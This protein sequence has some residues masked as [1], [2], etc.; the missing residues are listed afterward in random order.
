MPC[1][2]GHL[3]IGKEALPLPFQ[4]WMVIQGRK[5]GYNY[6]I[7]RSKRGINVLDIPAW[8]SS[9]KVCFGSEED[10]L[11]GSASLNAVS[12]ESSEMEC[13]VQC[14][15]ATMIDAVVDVMVRD[16]IKEEV[17]PRFVGQSFVELICLSDDD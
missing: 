12:Q 11:S 2:I 1:N 16:T 7:V 9:K 10:C 6:F 8:E 14:V 17:P 15:V 3:E 4:L 13:D 5:Y